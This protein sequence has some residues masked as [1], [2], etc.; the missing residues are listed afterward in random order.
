MFETYGCS[1][2][3][4]RFQLLRTSKQ[5]P[6]RCHDGQKQPFLNVRLRQVLVSSLVLVF[7]G[8]AAPNGDPVR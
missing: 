2:L 7:S 5:L 3:L 1:F 6:G 8:L 4:S